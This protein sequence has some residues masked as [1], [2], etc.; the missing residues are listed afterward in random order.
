M[1]KNTTTI[2]P[3]EGWFLLPVGSLLQEGDGFLHPGFQDGWI[4]YKCRPDIY[5]GCGKPGDWNYTQSNETAHTY[6]WR[7]RITP[8]P[9]QLTSA[10]ERM[11][12]V[13]VEELRKTFIEAPGG[14]T[15]DEEID[16]FLEA[17][18]ARLI[19]AVKGGQL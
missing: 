8:Q 17:I 19:E 13:P 2:D 18:R 16:S 5:R 11:Q 9:D 3:G 7:R 6:P 15:L 14:T 10:I 12:A 1:K 4:D